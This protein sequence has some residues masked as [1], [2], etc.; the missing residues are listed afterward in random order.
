MVNLIRRDAKR[1]ARAAIRRHE[2]DAYPHLIALLAFAL[3]IGGSIGIYVGVHAASTA[4]PNLDVWPDPGYGPFS[5]LDWWIGI[6]TAPLWLV[7]IGVM[8]KIGERYARRT[9][10][11]WMRAYRRALRRRLASYKAGLDHARQA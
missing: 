6:G 1:E 7:T 11:E 2:T 5:S 4:W 3:A 8:N 9:R 10:S